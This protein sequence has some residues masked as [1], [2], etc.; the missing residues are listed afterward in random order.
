VNGTRLYRLLLRF[1]PRRFREKYAGDLVEA[2][3]RQRLE[4]RYQSRTGALRFWR[5]IACDWTSTAL[6]LWTVSRPRTPQQ[7]KVG[8]MDPLVQDLRD[9]LRSIRRAPGFSVFV[10]F[11]L[12]MGI[13][14]NTVIFS[15]VRAV[16]FRPLPYANAERLVRI[17]ETNEELSR[18][19][20]GPSPANVM[21]WEAKTRAFAGILSVH[22][23]SGT[24]VDDTGAEEILVSRVSADFFS[25]LDAR[26]A[27]G[28]TFSR[29]EV[30]G[31]ARVVVLSH[32]FWVRRFGGDPAVVEKTLRLSGKDFRIV[33]VMAREFMYPTRE[34]DL[35]QP[36]DFRRNYPAERGGPPRDFR[37]LNVVAR[38][39]PGFSIPRAESDLKA[40]ASGIAEAAPRTNK[41]WSARIVPLHQETVRDARPTLLMLFG[42]VGF[43]LLI[44]CANVS[45]L[46]LVRALEREPQTV[47]KLALGCPRARLA[48][49]CLA[50]GVLLALAGGLAGLGLSTFGLR[51]LLAFYPGSLPRADEISLDGG[52]LAFTL[53]VSLACGIVFGLA[54]AFSAVER[55]LA[56][57]LPSAGS[58]GSPSQR[59]QALRRRLVVAEVALA[60][61]LCVG[62]GL[63]LRSFGRLLATAPGFDPRNLV[64]T[65]VR[66][67]PRYS[68][69]DSSNYYSTLLAKLEALPGVSSAAAVTALPLREF[70]SDFDRPYWREGA[71]PEG[72]DLP[73]VSIRMVTP[74]YFETM[75]VPLRSGRAFNDW[76]RRSASRVA[77]VN[78][79]VVRDLFAGEDPTGK[80]IVIDYQGGAYPYEVVGVAAPVRFYGLRSEP[81]AEAYLP[82]AQ[83]P[84]LPMNVVARTDRYDPTLPAAI[85]RV[86]HEMD[87]AQPIRDVTTMEALLSD[88]TARER[89]ALALV[90]F[91]A[92]VALGLAGTGVY[93]LL[94]YNLRQRRHEMGLRLA[95]GADRASVRRLILGESLRLMGVGGLLGL[96]VALALGRSIA[97]LLFGVPFWDPATLAGVA[98]VVPAAGLLAAYLPARRAARVDP[99]AALREP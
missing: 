17:W 34:S 60:V 48:R 13:G 94:T 44:A 73:E 46:F 41:G 84:Y 51:L 2:F 14:S 3:C 76:D 6:R 31:D 89:F 82:H 11:I 50:E 1:Y 86:T 43:V 78:D 93:S 75:R 99:V 80:R 38:L 77:I 55:R 10:V 67:D 47:V 28:R 81:V 53:A 45:S 62:A 74:R 71:R 96:G 49:Q 54:P 69:D 87:P 8:F 20:D 68:G 21:D 36:M 88:S 90:G 29:E 72:A 52:V 65:S 66:L 92:A 35:W 30:E 85:R 56:S 70:G 61:V 95:L 97:S 98:V 22:T 15:V 24:L 32:R 33:G 27:L 57:A 39:A 25:V 83:V 26:P 40:V 63:L 18:F 7:R 16:L 64:V 59:R 19:A 4:P 9:A 58:R 37:F 23:T 79:V 91:L 42:A 12:A 5:E